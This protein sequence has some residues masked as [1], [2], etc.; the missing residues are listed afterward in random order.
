MM[1]RLFAIAGFALFAS[2]PFAGEF[3]AA[4]IARLPQDKVAAIKNFAMPEFCEGSQYEALR[5]LIARGS[6]RVD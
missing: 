3:S 2:H 1:K 6:I 5:N 4:D